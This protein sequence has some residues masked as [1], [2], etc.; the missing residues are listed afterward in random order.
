MGFEVLEKMVKRPGRPHRCM[1]R[2][3]F[4]KSIEGLNFFGHKAYLPP[5]VNTDALCGSLLF[6]LDL[7]NSLEVKETV[8]RN[9]LKKTT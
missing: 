9:L 1:F 4:C 5:V 3:L 6:F 8:R 7:F 2:K